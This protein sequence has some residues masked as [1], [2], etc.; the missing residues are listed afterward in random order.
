MKTC[1]PH[2]TAKASLLRWSSL[3]LLQL[4]LPLIS[5]AQQLTLSLQLAPREIS[6]HATHA[7][8]EDRYGFIWLG[9]NGLYRYDGYGT[10]EY[11]SPVDSTG[12]MG[13]VR[14]LLEDRDGNI[15]IGTLGGLFR[16]ER[17]TDRVQ[18]FFSEKLTNQFGKTPEIWSL[19]EDSKGRIWVGS[20]DRLFVL[21]GPA[22][23]VIEIVQGLQIGPSFW[24]SVGIMDIQ[25]DA[26]G[27]IFAASTSGIWEVG[28][29]FTARQHLPEGYAR[30]SIVF[31]IDAATWGGGDTLWL[32]TPE[33]L[34]FFKTTNGHFRELPMPEN[35]RKLVSTVMA[36]AQGLLWVAT[37]DEV[38]QRQQNGHFKKVLGDDHYL[39]DGNKKLYQDRQGN[40]WFGSYHG[41]GMLDFNAERK[42]PFYQVG[43]GSPHHD[44]HF[45]RISQDSSG[46]FWFRMYR[47]GLGYCPQLGGPFEIRLQLP[48]LYFGEEVKGICTDADGNVWVVTYTNGLFFFE[49]GKREYR[50]VEMGD[51]LRRIAIP[52][53]IF[54]D[55]QNDRLLWISTRAGLC[56][57]DRF[58][59]QR[60]WFYPKNDLPWLDSDAINMMGQ[61]DD[62]NIWCNL[63]AGTNNIVGFFDRK[64]EMFVAEQHLPDRPQT[65]RIYQF[66]QV[67]PGEMWVATNRGMVVVDTRRKT[68]RFWTTANGFPTNDPLSL[69]PDRQ[70]NVWFTSERKIYKYDGQDF[71]IFEANEAI[72]RFDNTSAALTREGLVAFGG[73]NGLH[74]FDP[75]KMAK[76]TVRPKVYLTGFRV[77]NKKKALG[78]AYELVK[79]ITLPHTDNV[80]SFEFAGLHFS[81]S[82]RIRYRHMLD[83][84][85]K[86]WVETG[87]NERRTTYTNLAPGEYTFKV[88]AVGADGFWTPEEEALQIKL[89]VLP[90]WYATWWAYLLWAAIIGGSIFWFYKFQ[91][92]RQLAI[93]EARRLTELDHAKSLL[94]TNITHEFRTPLTII[95]GMAEQVKNDPRNWFSEGLKLIRRSG[96]QLL[97]LVN[98]LLDLSKLESG[99]M[100][101][102]LVNKD[103]VG[104]LEYLSESFHSYADSKDIRLHFASDFKKLDMDYDPKK[105]QSIVSNLL[106]NAIKF[107]P[108]GGDV[109][110]DVRF[111]KADLRLGEIVN[112]HSEIVIQVRDNGPGISPEHLPHVFDRFYQV[113]ASATR[114]GEGTGIGLALT[115]ELVKLM[116]GDITVES[117]LERGTKFSLQLPVTQSAPKS[118]AEE[119]PAMSL[120]IAETIL[121]ETPAVQNGTDIPHSELP[122]VLLIEDNADVI[123]Y[124]TS[125]LSGDY[126][127]ATATDG[128]QG[129]EKAIELTPDLVV[130]DVMMPEKDGFEVCETL[131]T[132]ERTSHIPVILLTAKAD[133]A[134]R[135]E[136]LTHGADAYLAKPFNKE[137]L[138]IRMEKLI[139]L[140]QRLQER[141]QKAGSLRHL[142]K[143]SVPTRDEAFLQKV[144]QVIENN[145]KDKD[146]GM[147]Q[148]CKELHLSR[149]HLFRKLK[150]LTGKSATHL[151]RAIR[152]EKGKE[153]L[154]TTHLNVSEVGYEVGFNNPNY[155]TRMFQETF[156]RPPSSFRKSAQ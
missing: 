152:I 9:G 22:A 41:A 71:E 61:A 155:F 66:Q 109:Y 131:K 14:A 138:L 121:L 122:L 113:D 100:P 11:L 52:A 70:G 82:R 34:W 18:P 133:M 15:W 45:Y 143:V 150:A 23:G 86:D 98:Q 48:V 102:E 154:E 145:L 91:L 7:I 40:L 99:H 132:D 95:L 105:L 46:G 56:R 76:D 64:I 153:L 39:F 4:W 148:L 97:S 107:T 134:A 140:R 124:L 60:K 147:P 29:D 44:N 63:K 33:G 79:E 49:K 137:E 126:R 129:I 16:Y 13:I 69:T 118:I 80:F 93:A 28:E 6:K 25:E 31:R 20:E 10:E 8:L 26:N 96:Q 87:S 12:G 57:L 2:K 58:T 3:L 114:R 127:I 73:V 144:V 21:T 116:G 17:Q 35:P 156:G 141:F 136:G 120:P 43:H 67:A 32:A 27:R 54:P 146:F 149:S 78:P 68:Q 55:N 111:T 135:L 104:F 108:A 125:F 88:A 19:F 75:E 110:V 90:P 42:L 65:S 139:A 38:F 5:N 36:D 85:E 83:G 101:L 119:L 59:L 112:R 62:G 142:L 30:G 94:Y 72:E 24:S 81:H 50:Q 84:F 1:T 37:K 53:A 128:Q 123:T 89:T 106:S 151:I 103:I 47:S 77:F 115:K 117:E 51:S 92:N 74:I 130:S